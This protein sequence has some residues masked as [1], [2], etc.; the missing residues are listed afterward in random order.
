MQI[1][2][3]LNRYTVRA[4]FIALRSFLMVFPFAEAIVL[5]LLLGLEICNVPHVSKV[6]FFNL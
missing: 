5:D 1:T 4:G 2:Q 3:A 6:E